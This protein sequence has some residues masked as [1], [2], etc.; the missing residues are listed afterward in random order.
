MLHIRYIKHYHAR[1]RFSVDLDGAL[2]Y[3]TRQILANDTREIDYAAAIRITPHGATLY[4]PSGQV[5]ENL[6]PAQTEKV[7]AKIA[8][9]FPML[10]R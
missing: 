3:A 4:A 2:E 9:L 8:V 7:K 5:L 6:T 10:E 1:P